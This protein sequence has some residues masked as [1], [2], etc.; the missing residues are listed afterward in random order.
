MAR[1]VVVLT[2]SVPVRVDE[3]LVAHVTSV[4][5]ERGVPVV[6]TDF[7]SVFAASSS[8]LK[9]AGVLIFNA[10]EEP[11]TLDPALSHDIAGLKVLMHLYEGLVGYDPRDASPI[12]AAAERWD[13]SAD[14]KTWT[15]HLRDGKWSNGDSVVAEDFV[16]AWRR[17][18][19][20]ETVCVRRSPRW[21]R[22]IP[23]APLNSAKNSS[24]PRANF[25]LV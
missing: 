19:Q 4:A 13:I 9:D 18:L 21:K 5:T 16:Y 25:N 15:F 22:A 20:P 6:V 12:P 24:F 23:S 10:G 14:G 2:E 3:A 8:P 7:S 17:V 1:T 11:G